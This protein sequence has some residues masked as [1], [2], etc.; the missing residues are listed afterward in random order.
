MVL[1]VEFVTDIMIFLGSCYLQLDKRE[2]MI[3]EIIIIM[4]INGETKELA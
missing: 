4:I 1:F 2:K 3:V